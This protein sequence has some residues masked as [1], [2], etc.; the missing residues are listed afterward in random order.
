MKEFK[1][2]F[3]ALIFILFLGARVYAYNFDTPLVINGVDCETAYKSDP[4]YYGFISNDCTYVPLRFISETL[5]F[6]V[7]YEEAS[8]NI[9]ISANGY[10]VKMNTK[11]KDYE[12]NGVKKTMDVA[13]IIYNN[14]TYIPIRYVAE[15]LNVDISWNPN[16]KAVYIGSA[17]KYDEK[18]LSSLKK[19]DF[20]QYGFDLYVKKDFEK[21]IFIEEAPQEKLVNFYDKNLYK[22]GSMN[23]LVASIG[24]ES[25]RAI[26]PA[27]NVYHEDGKVLVRYE[28]SDSSLK[29]LDPNLKGSDNIL[30]LFQESLVIPSKNI[31]PKFDLNNSNKTKNAEVKTKSEEKV[32]NKEIDKDYSTFTFG[33]PKVTIKIPKDLMKDLIVEKNKGVNGPVLYIRDKK[34][35]QEG[36]PTFYGMIRFYEQVHEKKGQYVMY[37]EMYKIIDSKGPIKTVEGIARDAQVDFRDKKKT[38]HYLDISKRVR[39]E[40]KVTVEK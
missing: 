7:N 24:T 29:K 34:T 39:E 23:G 25:E 2:L 5:N 18:D 11:S 21:N 4:N 40:V 8:R 36:D 28:F 26:F 31:F 12:T 16:D 35:A 17:I 3:F 15:A 22:K 37:D 27:L 13:P 33:N 1:K 9:K 6:N 19:L 14:R 10:E 32:V 30:K 38:S 20:S